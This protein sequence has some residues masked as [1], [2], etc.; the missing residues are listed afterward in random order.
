MGVANSFVSKFNTINK[1]NVENIIKIAEL[2]KNS[3]AT[4]KEW[5][6]E[7][8][9]YNTRWWNIIR[10]VSQ[11]K[12][13]A[14]LALY[15]SPSVQFIM[16]MPLKKQKAILDNP[17]IEVYNPQTGDFEQES[18]FRLNRILCKVALNIE[19]DF[20]EDDSDERVNVYYDK[21]E[22]KSRYNS[23]KE[24]EKEIFLSELHEYNISQGYDK[25]GNLQFEKEGVVITVPEV[26]AMNNY[27]HHYN[28]FGE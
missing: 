14:R 26:K 7:F 13:D 5:H 21:E 8:P 25:E 3:G 22:Q 6:E 11:N 15:R 20:D 24:S 17:F 19:Y 27:I 28:R 9:C 4:V 16:K 2:Y 23:L 10:L 1:H 18:I 12:V